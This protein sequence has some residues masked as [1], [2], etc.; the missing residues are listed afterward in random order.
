M[1]FLFNKK[2]LY[3]F[4]FH[5]LNLFLIVL[6]LFSIHFPNYITF[7]I[8]SGP[9]SDYEMKAVENAYTI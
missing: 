2:N 3:V 1:A 5:E 7:P 9:E 8:E 6:Q 4:I